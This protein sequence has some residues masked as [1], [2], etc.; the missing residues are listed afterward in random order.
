MNFI[1]FNKCFIN[2]KRI[3][4]L[5]NFIL[6]QLKKLLKTKEFCYFLKVC[7]E[8]DVLYTYIKQQNIRNV[9]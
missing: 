3:R 6:F 7:I 8:A 4:R 2:S 1:M 9:C 5:V